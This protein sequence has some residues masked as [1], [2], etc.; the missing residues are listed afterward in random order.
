MELY[1]IGEVP[2]E[3]G[4]AGANNPSHPYCLLLVLDFILLGAARPNDLVSICLS[5]IHFNVN[6]NDM[7]CK[8]TVFCPIN[9]INDGGGG[10]AQSG[11]A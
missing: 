5:V 11:D 10:L 8:C 2:A 1:D 7:A 4:V 9:D 3:G 6:V